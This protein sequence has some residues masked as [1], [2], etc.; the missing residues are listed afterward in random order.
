MAVLAA[1]RLW[2]IWRKRLAFLFVL[3]VP[4]LIVVGWNLYTRQAIAWD[5][6]GLPSRIHYCDRDYLPG[7]HL[8]RGQIEAI[9]NQFQVLGFQ[10]VGT[11][12]SGKSI[13]AKPL[14]DRVRYQYPGPPLPCD[15]AVYLKVGTD[16]Y[17]AYGLSGGP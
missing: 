13:Y 4:L 7:S 17:I 8:T 14:P 6:A 5:F 1:V 11:S 15:M 2:K 9:P 3:V 16:D 10:Q 12:A